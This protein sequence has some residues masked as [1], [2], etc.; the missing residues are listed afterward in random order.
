MKNVDFVFHAAAMKQIPS[1]EQ[2][3]LEAIKT[4]VL[5][6]ENVLNSAIENQVKKV[7]C[8]STDKAVAPTST[9]GLTKSL[10]EKIAL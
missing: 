4:N 5:G 9:M 8:L 10:M 6:S 3:P 7:V 1:C 2:N